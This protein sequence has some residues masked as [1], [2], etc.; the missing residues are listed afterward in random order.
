MCLCICYSHLFKLFK[1]LC[2]LPVCKKEESN[3]SICIA[4]QGSNKNHVLHLTTSR[5]D[6]KRP[7]YHL[8]PVSDL[9]IYGSR[10][11]DRKADF[12]C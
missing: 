1:F 4:S 12:L 11:S 5:V 2:Q 3:I 9:Q 8:I 10:I 6:K 7:S